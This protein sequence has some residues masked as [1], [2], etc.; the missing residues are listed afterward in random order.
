[1]NSDSEDDKRWPR[2]H[3]APKEATFA[4]GVIGT[5]YGR[6][7]WAFGG[8][9]TVTTG[10]PSRFVQSLLPKI[11]NNIRVGLIEEAILGKDFGEQ[12][13]VRVAHFLAGYQSLAF[14]RN[15][16]M[17]SQITGGGA[18]TAILLKTQRD[19][20]TVGCQL[21]LPELRKIADDMDTYRNFGMALTNHI[22]FEHGD[23]A[24]FFIVK[25]AP[26]GGLFPL[27]DKPPEPNRLRYTSGPFRFR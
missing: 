6:L 8:L 10:T 2:Y 4:L 17:H 7:E 11:T 21:T 9:F 20:K 18:T 1:M 22:T 26:A 19:G 15:M 3:D 25:N 24:Q 5:Q 14:N 27:P 12:I 23:G 16:L 13:E